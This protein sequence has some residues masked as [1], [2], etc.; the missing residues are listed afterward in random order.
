MM[1][2][3]HGMSGRPPTRHRRVGPTRPAGR[4][5]T[6]ILGE[7][8]VAIVEL[9]ADGVEAEPGIPSAMLPPTAPADRSQPSESQLSDVNPVR[10]P[11]APGF[12]ARHKALH[13]GPA[14]PP[15]A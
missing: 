12:A 7:P 10:A 14:P 13:P 9:A 6:P 4:A 8:L 15:G 11:A 2:L 3:R 5:C 1:V